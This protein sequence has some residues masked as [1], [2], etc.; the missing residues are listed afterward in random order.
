[1]N[2]NCIMVVD[3]ALRMTFDI[4]LY[5]FAKE[6]KP[7]Y[8]RINYSIATETVKIYIYGGLSSDNSVLDSI[9]SFDVTTYQF[10]EL[11]QRGDFKP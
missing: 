10:E 2:Q 8:A 1:M 5:G 11:T 3:P 6:N 7:K 9:E 4:K